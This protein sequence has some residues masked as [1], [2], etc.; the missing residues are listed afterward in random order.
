MRPTYRKDIDGLRAIAVLS[1]IAFH[2]SPVRFSGGFVGVDIFF[3]ISGYLISTIIIS[4]LEN[5]DFRFSDFYIR[6]IRRILPA[7]ILVLATTFALGWV[8]LMPEK[9]MLL[10]K[11]I[12][13]AS[14]FI[15]NF[16]LSEE[17]GYFDIDASI[18]PLL[19]IWSLAVEEQFYL[20]WPLALWAA[21][22]QNINLLFLILVI[23]VG[24]FIA[25]IVLVHSDPSGTF[26]LSSTRFWELLTGGVLAYFTIRKLNIIPVNLRHL[27][28]FSSSMRGDSYNNTKSLVG[29]GL[30]AFGVFWLNS[31]YA[32]P[33]WWALLPTT[34]AALLI[35][36]GP[37]SHVN[38]YLLSRRI[39]VWF[40]L[41]SY[42]LYLWHWPLLAFLRMSDAYTPL[43]NRILSVLFSIGLAWLTY[44]FVEHPLRFGGAARAKALLLV[45]GL[46][47]IGVI[48]LQTFLHKGWESRL[49]EELQQLLSV[50]ALNYKKNVKGWRVHRCFYAGDG[51][52]EKPFPE[53]CTEQLKVGAPKL[54]IWG[55]SSAASLMPGLRHLQEKYNFNLSQYTGTN[56]SFEL[57][58]EVYCKTLN[59]DAMKKIEVLNPDVV[60]L[61]SRWS[62]NY[63][64]R[65]SRLKKVVRELKIRGV[66]KIVLIGPMPIWQN[67]IANGPIRNL[68]GLPRKL[69]EYFL[70]FQTVPERMTYGLNT[71]VFLADKEL[72]SMAKQDEFQYISPLEILCKNSACL[73]TVKD[74]NGSSVLTTFDSVHLTP[75]AAKHLLIELNNRHLLVQ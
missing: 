67:T 53:E 21:W 40:G 39:F 9:Y 22:K 66:P 26:F 34:G 50:D 1:V 10:G 43:E 38:K 70:R 20:V 27:S 23:G 42:P 12:A 5:K 64:A 36:S 11:H 24:S 57:E 55:D 35:S 8:L 18:K 62:N 7:L 44:R 68:K 30:I 2:A 16:I 48:G 25:N 63:E 13:G 46:V 32:F 52:A 45:V 15:S 75:T 72:R 71:N 58:S 14:I 61:H 73:V 41:I 4:S 3:V 54:I 49:P 51:D 56:C 17:I 31:R 37:H 59:Q 69:Y 65:L 28:F 33:G 6:R 19:H 47:L 29:L 74:R 60:L